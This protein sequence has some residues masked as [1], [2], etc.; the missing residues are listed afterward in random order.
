M[1]KDGALIKPCI[2][3]RDLKSKNILIKSDMHTACISDFGLAIKWPIETATEAQGQ[4][5]EIKIERGKRKRERGDL[6]LFLL[7]LSQV[8]T[9][10]YMAPEVLEGAISFDREAYFRI[11]IYAFALILW[12]LTTRTKTVNGEAKC[13]INIICMVYNYG[14]S[15]VARTLT[16]HNA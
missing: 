5:S 11:D 4:V 2:A 10:R 15:V 12:E 1:I 6:H 7:F 14:D 8:G 13:R 3:H 16:R 9:A